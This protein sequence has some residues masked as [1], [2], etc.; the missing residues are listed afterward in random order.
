MLRPLLSIQKE[1][2]GEA[3]AT[4]KSAYTRWYQDY[5]CAECWGTRPAARRLIPSGN[6]L[7]AT[8]P[9]NS[10]DSPLPVQPQ[11]PED[12]DSIT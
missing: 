6:S 4:Y 12:P 5:R 8:S 7:M 10:H 11:E 3:F 2:R 9:G 1:L